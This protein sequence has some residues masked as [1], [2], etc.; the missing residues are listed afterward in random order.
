MSGA[1]VGLPLTLLALTPILA[2]CIVFKAPPKGKQV[3][4]DTVRVAFTVCASGNDAGTTCP[5]LGNVDDTAE[6]EEP[7]VVLLGFR[8]PVGTRL[9]DEI[10]P[11]TSDIPGVLRRADQYGGVLNDEAPTPRGF[12]WIGYRS[13][14]RLTPEESQARFRVD[15]GLPPS[16]R[17]NRFRF[18]P[19]VGY[20]NPSDER[21]ANRPIV[22]G[23]ALF[24]RDVSDEG[25]DRACIDSPSPDET[26]AHISVPI[27]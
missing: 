26:A 20:F 15:M 5:D 14:P 8:V 3:D 6:D 9:P 12:E 22:C 11:V 10:K 2:G 4:A 19:V 17:G 24:D 25:G 21:P 27:D 1:R 16:F 7:N 18:R 13:G 23:E